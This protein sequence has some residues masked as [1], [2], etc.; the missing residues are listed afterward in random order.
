MSTALL[1]PQNAPRSAEDLLNAG[2][3]NH[4]RLA[5]SL[6]E[7][8]HKIWSTDK[9]KTAFLTA[10]PADRAQALAAKLKEFDAANG[11]APSPAATAA[12]APPQAQAEP[13]KTAAAPEETSSKRQPKTA[14]S[15]APTAASAAPGSAQELLTVVKDLGEKLGAVAKGVDK[16]SSGVGSTDSRVERLEAELAETKALVGTLLNLSKV[17]IGLLTLFGQQVLGAGME[18]F[19]PAALG[20]ADKALD[21]L[22]Q[23]GGKDG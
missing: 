14:G 19:L 21:I 13:P 10:S 12:T 16:V 18:D 17:Q 1:S 2:V 8:G 4:R 5:E 6:F 23:S 15:P 7:L 3:F 22:E 9:E 20:D 11:G